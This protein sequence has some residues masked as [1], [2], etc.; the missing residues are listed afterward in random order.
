M[1]RSLPQRLSAVI[2]FRL[3]TGFRTLLAVLCF[4][5]TLLFA[6]GAFAQ[7]AATAFEDG[8]EKWN[9]GSFEEAL[10]LF[11]QALAATGSP[12][13]R[14]YV[15]RCLRDLGRL[16]EAHDEMSRTVKDAR[17]LAATE[18]RYAKTR[19]AAAGELAVLDG[20]VGRVI[21]ALDETVTDAYLTM[22]GT[23]LAKER[24]GVPVPV[25]PGAIEVVAQNPDGKRVAKSIEIAGGETKTVT[26]SMAVAPSPPAPVPDVPEEPENDTP[27]F[28]A[29]RGAGIAVAAVGVAGIIIF[30]VQNGV[31]DERLA[32]L[33]AEC[34]TGPCPNDPRYSTLIDEGETA[35]TIAGIGLG[36][37]VVGLLAGAAM[38]IFG[39]PDTPSSGALDVAPHPG[40]AA[41]RVRF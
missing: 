7:G 17:E 4:G 12:N 37:G 30:A 2:R 29:T 16:P 39:A 26:L 5:L 3:V 25:M 36:V 38:L 8:L 14:F 24:I 34:P 15:A 1:S 10:P 32:T 9:A 35:Q 41:L 23:T 18:E 40:G 33:E 19:D 20:R 13:A 22:N 28:S 31:A 11:K 21:V 27:W 6:G